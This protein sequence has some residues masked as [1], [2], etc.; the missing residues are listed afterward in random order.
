MLNFKREGPAGSQLLLNSNPVPAYYIIQLSYNL[1]GHLVQLVMLADNIQPPHL[2][3]LIQSYHDYAHKTSDDVTLLNVNGS[4][5][6][7]SWIASTDCPSLPI[8]TCTGCCDGWE[9][10]FGCICSAFLTHLSEPDSS[11]NDFGWLSAFFPEL[12]P[13]WRNNRDQIWNIH[14]TNHFS[15]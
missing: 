11:A 14:K 1:N 7:G 15:H 5:L 10:T 12:L 13:S 2:L 9:V 4:K 3:M 6:A 8:C